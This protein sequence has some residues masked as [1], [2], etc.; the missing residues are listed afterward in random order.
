[1]FSPM[2]SSKHALCI[3]CQAKIQTEQHEKCFNQCH[4]M[5][6]TYLPLLLYVTW[7]ALHAAQSYRSPGSRPRWEP[8]LSEGTVRNRWLW[9]GKNSPCH[10][11]KWPAAITAGTSQVFVSVRCVPVYVCVNVSSHSTTAR[12]EASAGISSCL[13][14]DSPELLPGLWLKVE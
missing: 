13:R 14:W 4:S 12:C 7:L 2:W 3:S 1:M 6:I 9:T 11:G 8:W 5:W 10:V